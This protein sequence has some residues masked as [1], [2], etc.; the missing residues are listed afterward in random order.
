MTESRDFST[1]SR[2]EF[3]RLAAAAGMAGALA[4][5][6]ALGQTPTPAAAP[7]TTATPPTVPSAAPPAPPSPAPPSDAARA[8][9]AALEQRIGK[10]KLTP[11]QWESVTR[12]FDSDIAVGKRL[13]GSKL[14]NGDEPD[15]AFRV[16]S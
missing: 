3:L 5:V 10:D 11:E 7:D 13:A 8:L 14:A 15:F 4:P 12:D 1:P 16:T 2:R 9:A 6:A